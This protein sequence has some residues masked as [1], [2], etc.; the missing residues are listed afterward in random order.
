M[1][2]KN[3]AALKERL[4]H[5]SN[6]QRDQLMRR[7][8]NGVPARD[9]ALPLADRSLPVPLSFAQLQL[10]MLN[11]L[12]SGSAAYNVPFA[13]RIQGPADVPALANAFRELASR[14]E[15]LR[16]TFSGSAEDVHQVIHPVPDCWPLPVEDL[17]H[18][19]DGEKESAVTRRIAELSS[20][21]FDLENGPLFRTYLLQAAAHDHVLVVN[22]HHIVADAW[23]IPIVLGEVSAIYNSIVS[24][25][26]AALPP[27][28]RQ[29]ADFAAWQ[30]HPS[31]DE[32]IQAD[33]Q[34]WRR[35]LAGVATLDLPT[36]LPRPAVKTHNG[37]QIRSQIDA[38]L[39][40]ALRGLSQQL[41]VSLFVTLL[42]AFKAL[43][44]LSTGQDDICVGTVSSI[45][46]F[47]ETENLIGYFVNTLALR[48][49]LDGDPSFAELVERVNTV[50]RQALAHQRCP[51]EKLV[52]DL[53]PPRDLSRTPFFQVAFSLQ[54]QTTSHRTRETENVSI[55]LLPAATATAKFD[56]TLLLVEGDSECT[57]FLEFNTDLFRP[58]TCERLLRHYRN[59]L[60]QVASDSTRRLSQLELM[61][62]EEAETILRDWSRGPAVPV[63]ARNACQLFEEQARK[64]PESEA[65]L[66]GEDT[67]T[68]HDL[69]CRANRL[70]H[71]LRGMGAGPE[72]I[73]GVC[74][75]RSVDQVVAVLAVLKAGA[76][77]LPLD[78]NYPGARLEHMLGDSGAR[79]VVTNREASAACTAPGF[80]LIDAEKEAIDRMSAV[81]PIPALDEANTAYVI[82]TSGSTGT[83]RG[84]AVT[85]GGLRNLVD[86]QIAAFG[87]TSRDRVLQFAS[88][89]FDASVSEIFTALGC[90][91]ALILHSADF[92]S[93]AL[94]GATIATFPPSFLAALPSVEAPQTIVSAGEACPPD[95]VRK[96]AAGRTFIN[97][98]GPTEATVCATAA[99]CNAGDPGLPPIGR[100]IN[101]VQV[102]VLDAYLRPR[103]AGLPG[104]LY[105]GG[106]GVARGYVG[107]PALTAG[108]FVPD[109]FSPTPGARLYRTGD[110]AAWRADGQ[111]TFLGRIDR[112]MKVRGFRIEPGE[113]EA[114]LREY[115]G[116]ADAAVLSESDRLTAYVV[117]ATNAVTLWP[118][119]SEYLLYDDLLYYAMLNDER[120]NAAYRRAIAQ[121]VAGRTVVEIGAGPEAFLARM[122]IEEGA[123]KVYAIELLK[124]SFE[125]ARSR[126]E[127]LGLTGKISLI[128]GDSRNVHLPE[129]CSVC[130]S[131]IVGN[132]GGS[133]G[134][135]YLINDARRFLTPDAAIIPERSI[136]R[137]AAVTL[138]ESFMRGPVFDA[139]APSYVEKVFAAHGGAFDLRLCVKGAGYGNLL[140]D[141][142]NF[143]DLDFRSIVPLASAHDIELTI[144]APGRLDGFF[145]WLNLHTLA[146]LELDA[147][148]NEHC[149]LPVFLP[150][151][152][153]G[154]PVRP[155]DRIL[156]HIVRSVAA[157]GLSPDFRIRGTLQR[158]NDLLP[159]DYDCSHTPGS[160]R[161]NAFCD[162]LFANGM[163][164]GNTRP[165]A[166][167]VMAHLRSRLPEYMVPSQIV[168]M[169]SLPL[170]PNGK[171]DRAALPSPN[172]RRIA[173]PPVTSPATEAEE[174][175]AGIWKELLSLDQ[176]SML[177]NFFDLGGHSLSVMRLRTRLLEEF[178]TAPSILEI[179]ERPTVA[180]LAAFYSQTPSAVSDASE[181]LTRGETRASRREMVMAAR[182]RRLQYR[183]EG[184]EE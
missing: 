32:A 16:T 42:T 167:D 79:L 134:A 85:H 109:P 21:P 64:A 66:C 116:I 2:T 132:I 34:Y 156:A 43:L 74:L 104:E 4:P 99:V 118:S 97:A 37:A 170:T 120:R 88:L 144:S 80:V 93:P 57:A 28:P 147:L 76:A 27:L 179:F 48:S 181:G 53:N 163:V 52:E 61:T 54:Q 1:S 36:D 127:S 82:Y 46:S 146:G 141:V 166:P 123:H 106:P 94:A 15:I 68:Y 137:I 10:W 172:R 38:G 12:S 107:K 175:I 90:G 98:Y 81:D 55:E 23:S 155:G 17:S 7:L 125:Q 105:I 73:I 117:P 33:V 149:W 176:V 70:A 182:H 150:A 140:S 40:D 65:I 160:F 119:M 115:P 161:G 138:P 58:D 19:L 84:V 124:S 62:A 56:L 47:P 49:P 75:P 153:F 69:N 128:H 143:E 165:S 129:P 152:G 122:C 158:G 26:P 30:R 22:M 112:Q 89:S 162:T 39:L 113:V 11:Q 50:F 142:R 25:A 131:E 130:V 151:F 102:Y 78:P 96:F 178:K 91:A 41:G 95:V 183:P 20:R 83:P 173:G 67:A 44:A 35:Q 63:D 18:G 136:T 59:V 92:T 164:P 72:T 86:A 71:Y 110:L 139:A 5:L 31:Q 14:H 133:E 174:K 135:A 154:V 111:L 6:A 9:I 121:T 169:D 180:A 87:I 177:D 29:Y 101:N 77:Y 24:G 13:V 103:P 108:R 159:F 3:Y 157:N 126:I 60:A 168:E 45:R 8:V 51:F 184:N 145:V 171:I 114:A 148:Q 100:P